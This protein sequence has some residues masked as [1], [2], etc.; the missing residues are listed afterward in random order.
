MMK[1]KQYREQKKNWFL[2]L[3]VAITAVMVGLIVLGYF[4]TPYP[5]AAMDG[6]C[7]FQAPVCLAGRAR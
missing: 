6:A 3:G 2:I 4:W 1:K 7:K 5:P